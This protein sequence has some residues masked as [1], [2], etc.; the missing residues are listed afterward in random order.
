MSG[1][2]RRRCRA[3][4][5]SAQP[6]AR[7]AD[8]AESRYGA[9]VALAPGP[10][11]RRA[12]RHRATARE[13]PPPWMLPTGTRPGA[14]A[15][16]ATAGDSSG[17]REQDRER[18]RDA[19]V[20]ATERSLHP[21]AGDRGTAK[22][23]P[24]ARSGRGRPGATVPSVSGVRPSLEG[25]TFEERTFA[26][27]QND[28]PD[29]DDSR[30]GGDRRASTI[31]FADDDLEE[32]E[33]LE[34][35][36]APGDGEPAG[37]DAAAISGEET[38]AAPGSSKSPR[39]RR[40]G[41]RGRKKAGSA[42]IAQSD[43]DG[44]GLTSQEDS[45]DQGTSAVEAGSVPEIDRPESPRPESLRPESLR[46]LNEDEEDED[47]GDRL[48]WEDAEDLEP[49]GG[50]G[51]M[52]GAPGRAAGTAQCGIDGRGFEADDEDSTSRALG[53]PGEL[54]IADG[55]SEPGTESAPK[56]RRRRRGGRGR[57]KSTTGGACDAVNG[58]GERSSRAHR[59]RRARAAGDRDRR[60]RAT[61]RAARGRMDLAAAG[62][63]PPPPVQDRVRQPRR[64]RRRRGGAHGEP[65]MHEGRSEGRRPGASSSI[66]A[67]SAG[68][69]IEGRH[70]G[71]TQSE[72]DR[73]PRP[74]RAPA[75]APAPAP[76][77]S[78]PP[79]TSADDDVP[80]GWWSRLRGSKKR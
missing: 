67:R 8:G 4:S 11:S 3:T 72:S 65:S 46:P 32:R 52:A 33:T 34:E 23:E 50:A 53:S 10:T 18:E 41:G 68:T 27:P 54:P 31:R 42:A 40:R 37:E 80:G 26:P 73:P 1:L 58:E 29:V 64:R 20:T 62:A 5:R 51:T 13:G 43:E 12:L 70:T 14:H 35:V 69:G 77:P 56:K 15:A 47:A 57:R 2:S 55:G 38:L 71:P 24:R 16:P 78:A 30:F 61:R 19:N 75:P 60:L 21:E 59:G 74:D 22:G 7:G 28:R 63:P 76:H 39:R 44:G 9:K 25:E 66:A 45:S 6:E 49:L 36:G 48:V 79:E 17:D